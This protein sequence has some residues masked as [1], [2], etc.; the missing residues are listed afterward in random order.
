[1]VYSPS[2]RWRTVAL[3]VAVYVA[4]LPKPLAAQ[5]RCAFV[6]APSVK[7]EPTVRA[8]SGTTASSSSSI[9]PS[10][11]RS[12]RGAGSRAT[13]TSSTRSVPARHRTPPASIPTNSTL[14]LIP[15]F[16]RQ[17]TLQGQLAAPSR[18]GGVA[19]LCRDWAPQGRGCHRESALSRRCQPV[20]L[21]SCWR[22]PAGAAR[23]V[24]QVVRCRDVC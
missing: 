6:R 16:F 18:G 14:N 13:S 21:L 5:P 20:V 9:S 10:W 12:R 15:A 17:P 4:L 1:M 19:R 23:P 22:D 11:N 8:P 7:I 24:N 3:G 2:P